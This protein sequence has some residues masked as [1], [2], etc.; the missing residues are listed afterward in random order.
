MKIA[1]AWRD[2]IQAWLGNLDRAENVAECAGVKP[3]L[4]RTVPTR[5]LLRCYSNILRF[6]SKFDGHLSPGAYTEYVGRSQHALICHQNKP[7]RQE[8]ACCMC[9]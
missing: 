3:V 8:S 1:T 5:G 6:D 2:L 9:S 4:Q 7:G